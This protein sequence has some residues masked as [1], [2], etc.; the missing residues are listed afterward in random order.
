MD[1]GCFVSGVTKLALTQ[2][3]WR[4]HG[5][6]RVVWRDDQDV[7]EAH[8]MAVAVPDRHERGPPSPHSL[9]GILISHQI[10]ASQ[11]PDWIIERIM[12]NFIPPGTSSTA[13]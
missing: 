4:S 5:D 7:I 11:T 13:C 10:R 3:V 12:T 8:G 2:P 1:T 9:T 6:L